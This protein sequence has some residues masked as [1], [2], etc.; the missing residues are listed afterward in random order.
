MFIKF[1][2]KIFFQ[3]FYLYINFKFFYKMSSPAYIINIE[4]QE[5]DLS[6]NE[7]LDSETQETKDYVQQTKASLSSD[8]DS[9]DFV[10][11]YSS[12]NGEIIQ[13]KNSPTQLSFKR[14]LSQ[15]NKPEIVAEITDG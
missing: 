7:F 10:F 14:A 12:V 2:L 3:F 8:S 9:D 11:L 1:S 4:N 13:D 5:S 6:Q 15:E